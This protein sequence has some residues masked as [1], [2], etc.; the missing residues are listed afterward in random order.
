MVLLEVSKICRG[1]RKQVSHFIQVEP[2]F[3]S[4]HFQ[5]ESLV[6]VIPFSANYIKDKINGELLRYH[7]QKKLSQI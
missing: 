6:R 7:L 5:F 4:A 2:N 1:Q 3:D